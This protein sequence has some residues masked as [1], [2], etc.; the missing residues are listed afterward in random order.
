[1]PDA[2]DRFADHAERRPVP[3]GA[4]L[5]V[6]RD[7]GDDEIRAITAQHLCAEAKTF[8]LPRAEIFNHGIGLAG[9]PYDDFPGLFM[10]QVERDAAFVPAML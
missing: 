4:I 1:M 5:P 2:A 6:A 10:F 9:Q 8:K 7:M 3:V